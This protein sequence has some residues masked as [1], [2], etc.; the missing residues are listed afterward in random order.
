MGARTYSV[1]NLSFNNVPK[2][3]KYQFPYKEIIYDIDGS[4]TG[5]GSNSWAAAYYPHLLQ[6]ECQLQSDEFD[7]VICNGDVQI[8]SLIFYDYAPDAMRMQYFKIA[9]WDDDIK[10]E[11]TADNS[12]LFDFEQDVNHEYFTRLMQ[13]E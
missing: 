8:R 11:I 3:I 2:K 13:R 9:R 5:L 12:T 7:G 4:L 1:N 6:P 10:A